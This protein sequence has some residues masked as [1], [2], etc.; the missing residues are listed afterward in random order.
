MNLSKL[1]KSRS[2]TKVE[3]E[4]FQI[5]DPDKKIMAFQTRFVAGRA[6][7]WLL[8]KIIHK[9]LSNRLMQDWILH[10]IEESGETENI[11]PILYNNQDKVLRKSE[12]T[13]REVN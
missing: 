4:Y 10:N 6:N 1:K 3:N 12:I 2:I 8:N 9:S 7:S 5:I 13:K 11:L